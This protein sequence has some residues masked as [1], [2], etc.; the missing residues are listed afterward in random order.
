MRPIVYL[1]LCFTSIIVSFIFACVAMSSDQPCNKYTKGIVI[2]LI[3]LAMVFLGMA[4][5]GLM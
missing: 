5:K 4:V 1:I 2:S 3:G